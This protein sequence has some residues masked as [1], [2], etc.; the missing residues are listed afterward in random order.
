MQLLA[1]MVVLLRIAWCAVIR[2]LQL[3]THAAIPANFDNTFKTAYLL[4]QRD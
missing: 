1:I 2:E 3:K 4:N